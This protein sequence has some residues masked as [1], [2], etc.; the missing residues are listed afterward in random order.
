MIIVHYNGMVDLFASVE[1]GKVL[2]RLSDGMIAERVSA[3]LGEEAE[4]QEI[5]KPEEAEHAHD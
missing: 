5:D 2:R 3:P 4:W 1:E